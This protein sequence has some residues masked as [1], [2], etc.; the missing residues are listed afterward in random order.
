MTLFYFHPRPFMDGIGTALIKHAAETSFPSDHTTFM[1]SIA[2]TLLLIDSTMKWAILFVALGAVGG[3]SRVFCGIHYPLDI[4]GSL[5]VA[6]ISSVL[7]WSLKKKIVVVNEYVI[8]KYL[9]IVGK[10]IA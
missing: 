7:I 4:L 8:S 9:A 5:I 3:I 1:L 10:K 2:T 6:F